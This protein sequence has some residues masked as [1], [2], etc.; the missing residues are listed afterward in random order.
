MTN[1]ANSLK[2]ILILSVILLTLLTGGCIRSFEEESRL[3]ISDIAVT[4]EK[5]RS[6]F[7]DLS[8]I[9]SI[10]N[11]GEQ[12]ADN[13]SLIL[14]A[15]NTKTGFLESEIEKD[16]ESIDKGSSMDSSISITLPKRDGYDLRIVLFENDVEIAAS[17]LQ[18]RNL[19]SL[20]PDV[21][22]TGIEIQEM[23][24]LVRDVEEGKVKI[25]TDIYLTNEGLDAGADYRMLVKAREMDT[26][27]LADKVWTSTSS[28]APDATVIRSVNLTVP[29][30]YNYAVE[31]MLWDGDTIVRQGE[32]YVQL[33]P[34]IEIEKDTRVDTKYV[35]TDD[36]IMESADEED[37][38]E[39][40]G[41]AMGP[42][43]GSMTAA[44][45]LLLAMAVFAVNRRKRND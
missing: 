37:Y 5:I 45:S 12:S 24:F 23:D 32:D 18:I 16:I 10:E 15:Y 25:Q 31:V 14:K 40:T 29:D 36:F 21:S 34:M 42:G 27:L 26:G 3:H 8:V 19:D 39:D 4:P 9:S 22:E 20:P 28:F 1:P 6:S 35:D 17:S 30:N 13:V 33:N 2:I 38:A 44:G 41:A 7:V 43:F 11:R